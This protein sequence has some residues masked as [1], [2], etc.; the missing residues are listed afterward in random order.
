MEPLGSRWGLTRHHRTLRWV[1]PD[2]APASGHTTPNA[3]M[4]ATCPFSN[5]H[6]WS[7]TV[8]GNRSRTVRGAPDAL[9]LSTWRSTTQRSVWN[10]EVATHCV[11]SLASAATQKCIG[12]AGVLRPASARSAPSRVPLP[13]LTGRSTLH[14]VLTTRAFGACF[15]VRNTT[16]TSPPLQLLLKSANQLVYHLV[17]VY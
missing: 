14:L 7:S 2:A 5:K 15:S 1:A 3:P 17:H 6:C 12:R 4:D 13:E 11:R 10:R 16:A 8:T 9:V